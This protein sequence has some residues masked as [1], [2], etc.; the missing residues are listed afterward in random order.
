MNAL[1]DIPARLD[2]SPGWID[3][4][5]SGRHW[6]LQNGGFAD[7]TNELV[8]SLGLSSFLCGLL[9][10]RGV[11]AADAG[12]FL[13]PTLRQLLPEPLLLADMHRAVDRVRAAIER[14]EQIA[15]FGDYDVDGSCSAALLCEFLTAIGHPP[16]LYT[17]DRMTEGY[18]PNAAALLMLK[19]EGASL[20]ITVDCGATASAPLATARDAGLDVIV[21]DHHATEAAVPAFAHVN[22][23]QPGD[24]SGLGHLCAAGV[25]FLFAVA[26]NR[27]LRES[28]WY[29]ANDLS[30]PDL[31][32]HLDLVALATVCDVVPIIGVNRAFVRV[33]LRRLCALERPGFAALAAV[34]SA[35]PPFTPHHLS[36]VFGPRIN[37]GGRIGRCSLGTELLTA[38]AGVDELADALNRHNRERRAIETTI[39]EEATAIAS[40]QSD[41]PILIVEGDGWHS[42]VVGII[43]GRLRERFNKPAIAIGFEGRLGRG[44]ARSVPGF[45]IGAVVRSAREAAILD[46][47]GGHAMAAGLSLMRDRLPAFREF[48]TLHGAAAA[49][50]SA[51]ANELTIDTLVSAAACTRELIAEMEQLGP[52]GPGNPEPIVAISDARIAYADIVGKDHVRLGLT[53]AEGARVDAIAF[54]AGSAPLGHGLLASRGKPVHVAGRLRAEE[55]EGR[56]RVQLHVEDA[57]AA[58]L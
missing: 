55:W 42:G 44:S 13:N 10:A 8:R 28:G 49:R 52:F 21:L 16:R 53:G 46:S 30:E 47:G 31:R 23:N 43:A 20:V 56:I 36:F 57:A 58:S 32:E 35:S 11:R 19:A 48:V 18:G 15:V 45:D 5:F 1:N 7:L 33:G 25:T 26:L 38:K 34:A 51:A 39:L 27:A 6:R 41:S 54:R 22:P 40:L 4:S 50:S 17:P 37:A 3:R 2:A 24:Q 12:N 9:A 29:G 14:G